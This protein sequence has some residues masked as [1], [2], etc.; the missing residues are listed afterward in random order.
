MQLGILVFRRLVALCGLWGRLLLLARRLPLLR[1]WLRL[2]LRLGLGL[3]LSLGLLLRRRS[4]LRRLRL[5]LLHH[6]LVLLLCLSLLLLRL[7]IK[8]AVSPRT[9]NVRAVR[10]GLRT[11]TLSSGLAICMPA[12]AGSCAIDIPPMPGTMPLA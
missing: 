8:C 3:G 9:Y 5:C 4:R 11:C 1:R 7:R 2:G 12:M 6:G 10:E